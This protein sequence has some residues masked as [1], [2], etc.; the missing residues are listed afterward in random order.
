MKTQLTEWAPGCI[1]TAGVPLVRQM[2]VSCM[3][4]F[5]PALIF[6]NPYLYLLWVGFNVAPTR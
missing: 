6:I 5:N 1:G 3:S 2:D 4:E